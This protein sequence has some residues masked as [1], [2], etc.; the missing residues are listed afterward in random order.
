MKRND[1]VFFIQLSGQSQAD[2]YCPKFSFFRAV[3][4]VVRNFVKQHAGVLFA[5]L[6][7]CKVRR[8]VIVTYNP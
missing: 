8:L 7:E 1:A 3:I 2:N 5:A 4:A 6:N